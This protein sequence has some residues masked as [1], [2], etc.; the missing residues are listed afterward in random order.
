[1]IQKKGLSDVVT[2]VLI[3]LLVLAAV[4]IIWNFIRPTIENSGEAVVGGSTCFTVE[5]VPVSCNK[6]S[7]VFIVKQLRGG[8][9]VTNVTLIV[10]LNSGTSR[11]SSKISPGD[12]ATVSFLG[13]SDFGATAIAA[14]SAST[15]TAAS[16]VT[17][18]ANAQLCPESSVVVT[19]VA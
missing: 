9:D 8:S 19:C 18:N 13:S 12:G 16:V 15:I 11:V 5:A 7:G 10:R 17:V 14:G 4:V 1:M 3:I 6:T 2:T